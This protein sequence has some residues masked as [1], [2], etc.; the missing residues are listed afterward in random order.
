MRIL[1]LLSGFLA[2]LCAPLASAQA[3]PAPA[4]GLPALTRSD[5][6]AWLDGYMPYALKRGDIAGAV[7]VVVKDGQVLLQKGYGYSDLAK[8][9]PVDPERTLFRPG[10]VSK[11]FTW[12]AV[13]QLVEQGKVDLD[14]DI[15]GY[16]DFTIPPIDG[17]PV[18]LR[19]VM[20]H[21]TGM[22]EQ[23][24]GLIT[25]D[26]KGITSLEA[27][28]KHWVPVRIFPAG[29]TPAYS[30]YAT[31]LAGYVVERVSGQPFDDYV[32]EHLFAP[33][34]MA[35][36][37]FRQPLPGH[38]APLV[39]K[40]YARASEGTAKPYE[41]INLAPAG[42]LAATGSDMAK[43]M[44]AHLNR[45]AYGERRILSAATAETM[46]TTAAE[47][48]GPLNR[49]MLGFY[50]TN[51]N[52]HRAIAHGG[53][54]QWFH[55]YL[56]LFPDDNIGLFVSVNSTGKEGAAGLV[57][58]ALFEGFADRYLPASGSEESAWVDAATAKRHA[59]QLA[60]VY[61]NSRRSQTGFISLAFFL[62]QVK[63]SA[64]KDGTIRVAGLNNAAG[65]PKVFKEIAPYVWRDVDGKDRIA[66]KVVDGRVTRFSA[67]PFSGFML[68][69]R[70]PWWRS[71]VWIL[72]ALA[73]GLL[74]MLLTVLS[75]PIGSL[76]RRHY[77]V[78]P[79]LS[80][81][82]ASVQRRIRLSALALVLVMGS[83][84]ALIVSMLS[85]FDMITPDKDWLVH[86]TR[87]VAT[88]VLPL[89]T[90]V[91]L[92][93]VRKVLASPGRRWPAKLWAVLLALSALALLYIAAIFNILGYSANY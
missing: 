27:A 93:N 22:E 55:S 88:V 8:Q 62:G 30:N 76:V 91:L 71:S 50:E 17:K 47:T 9:S 7:V 24:R 25:T 70:A 20:T 19:Q 54:T 61:D 80:A 11:L 26:P 32:D 63:V 57:R 49:M 89:A 86:L 53:D 58:S 12:T 21:R 92:A 72:P 38:L 64:A 52:G 90:L 14:K 33:L 28:L 29:S 3:V 5:A 1:P 87:V 84:V 36:S 85:D 46:H 56:H 77:R 44:I 40:G 66:A 82:D 4:E 59:A 31:A 51:I 78:S 79:R 2:A 74:A 13:M 68:F 35:R 39:S 23:V 6:E 41:Y 34:G 18:T 48:I 45:G 75:W 67:D 37:S 16:I 81:S 73:G 69:E 83:T 42:S 65:E 10:S 60:G 15:N 43:F